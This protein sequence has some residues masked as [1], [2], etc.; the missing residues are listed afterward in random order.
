VLVPAGAFT[1]LIPNFAKPVLDAIIQ[2]HPPNQA[3]PLVWQKV[4]P[5]LGSALIFLLPCSALAMLSPYLIRLAALRLS[6]VGRIAGLLYAASTVGG[7]GGVFVSGYWLIDH[8]S[9]SNIFRCM[10]GL[11]IALGLACLGLDSWFA[12]KARTS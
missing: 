2:R 5:A 12:Q 9:V 1:I 3:I 4:D 11:T 6:Q 7:I 10:G 8:L